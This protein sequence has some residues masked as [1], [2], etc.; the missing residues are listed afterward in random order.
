MPT[1]NLGR[2]GPCP[3]DCRSPLYGA[4][5]Q[6]ELWVQFPPRAARRTVFANVRLVDL[7]ENIGQGTHNMRSRN[8]KLDVARRYGSQRRHDFRNFVYFSIFRGGDVP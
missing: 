8:G 3:V 5:K 7:L 2:P 4:D 6:L 1:E